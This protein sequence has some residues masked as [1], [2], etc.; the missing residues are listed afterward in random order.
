MCDVIFLQEHWL[1][2]SQLRHLNF[3]I[4][5]QHA[6]GY[7]GSVM[8]KSFA[9]GRMEVAPYFG[10]ETCALISRLY[11][12]AGSGRR[13]CALRIASDSLKPLLVNVYSPHEASDANL[14]DFMLLLSPTDDLIIK[15]VSVY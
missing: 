14:D 1:S 12:P 13:S 10:I 5:D 3:L 2:S 11:R 7:L 9:G 8:T 4:S 6:P 15:I